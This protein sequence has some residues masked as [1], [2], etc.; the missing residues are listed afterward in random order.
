MVEANDPS[1]IWTELR[2][3]I[4]AYAILTVIYA[5]VL[6]AIYGQKPEVEWPTLL[7]NL[8][9]LFGQSRTKILIVALY[10]FLT[11][12]PLTVSSLLLFIY[13][14][15]FMRDDSS[16]TPHPFIISLIIVVPFSLYFLIIDQAGFYQIWNLSKTHGC[17]EYEFVMHGKSEVCG[18]NVSQ[19]WALP[20]EILNFYF[21]QYKLPLAVTSIILGVWAGYRLQ[22]SILK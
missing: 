15:L 11:T 5:F 21:V 13:L 1:K 19:W 10:V 12:L 7:Q 4:I 17:L 22:K 9:E 14:S 2:F 6:Y 3:I 18:H 8:V 16:G 20:W